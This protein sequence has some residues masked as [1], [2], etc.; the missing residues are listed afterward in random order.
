MLSVFLNI[1]ICCIF[2]SCSVLDIFSFFTFNSQ[3]H[4]KEL[5][6]RRIVSRIYL[7]I[8]HFCCSLFIT[9]VLFPSG[10]IFLLSEGFSL[11]IILKQVCWLLVFPHQNFFHLF[12]LP[13]WRIFL[14]DIKLWF[15]SVFPCCTKMLFHFPLSSVVTNENSTAIWIVTF[16]QIMC[17]FLLVNFRWVL[18]WLLIYRFAYNVSGHGFLWVYPV[19]V[20]WASWVCRFMSFT[21]FGDF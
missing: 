2:H 5:K 15:H 21:K 17:Y 6:R 9:N 8:Y 11:T 18:L 14:L 12:C 3:K 10:S 16:L 19:V 4:F 1:L 7:Y 13:S 20:C